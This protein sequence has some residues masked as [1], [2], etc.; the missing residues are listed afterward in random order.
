MQLAISQLVNLLRLQGRNKKNVEFKILAALLYF[1][2]IFKESKNYPYS[3]Q[4]MNQS[5]YTTTDS[6]KL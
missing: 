3:R 1:F 5:E 6:K 2:G 4:V